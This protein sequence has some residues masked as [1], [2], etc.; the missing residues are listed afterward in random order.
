MPQLLLG[1]FGSG[2]E[3]GKKGRT[4]RGMAQL[5]AERIQAGAKI[6]QVPAQGCPQARRQRSAIMLAK[7]LQ[8]LDERAMLAEGVVHQVPEYFSIVPPSLVGD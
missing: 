5:L 7:V 3:V 1:V 2:V 4:R 6:G 8:A